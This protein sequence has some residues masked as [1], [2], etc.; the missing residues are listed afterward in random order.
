MRRGSDLLCNLCEKLSDSVTVFRA[1]RLKISDDIEGLKFCRNDKQ[2]STSQKGKRKRTHPTLLI[3]IRI[4]GTS[5]IILVDES[6]L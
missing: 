5:N 2:L 1:N 3:K 4:V 6:R